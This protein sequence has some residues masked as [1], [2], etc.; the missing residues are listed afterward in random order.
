MPHYCAVCGRCFS[1][2][3]FHTR[4]GGD[5]VRFADFDDSA[6]KLGFVPGVVGVAW[7]CNEHLKAARE[8]GTLGTDAAV[9][10]IQQAFGV[11][12]AEPKEG[13]RNPELILVEFGANRARVFTIVHQA[14]GLS[15][16]EVKGLLDHLPA[17]V[18]EGWPSEF[19]CWRQRLCE[20]GA[21]VEVRWD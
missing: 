2:E 19:E 7:I 5:L 11:N 14:T 12:V 10:D 9:R 21:K 20:A 17:K 1:N 6:V 16:K 15:P 13:Q 3:Y 4:G 8:R 18:S